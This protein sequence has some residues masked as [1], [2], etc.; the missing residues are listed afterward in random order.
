MARL[1]SDFEHFLGQPVGD[2]PEE[3]MELEAGRRPVKGATT[4][5]DR[6]RA[7]FLGTEGNIVEGIGI[8]G[9]IC[10]KGKDA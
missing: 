3:W 6:I 2:G 1:D 7:R 9:H 4:Q 10:P 8:H 5:P